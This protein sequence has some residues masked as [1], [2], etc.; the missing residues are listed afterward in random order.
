MT[1]LDLCSGNPRRRGYLMSAAIVL[2]CIGIYFHCLSYGITKSDD[3][4][5]ITN[6]LPFLQHLPNLSKVFTTDAFYQHKSIDLYRPLQ[7]ATFILDAQWGTDVVFTAHLTNLILHILTCLTV[8]SLLKA[9]DFRE[10]FAFLG[11]LIYS[12]H[13]LFM[14]AV[15]WLPARGDLLLALCSFLALLFFIRAMTM[16]GWNN[17]LLHAVCFVCAVFSKESAGVLPVVLA[18]YLWSYGQMKRARIPQL[19]FLFL[20]YLGVLAGYHFLKS[21]AVVLYDGDTGIAPLLKNFRTLPETMAKFFIPLNV[22]T[23]PAYTVEATTVGCLII[24]GMGTLLF[25]CRHKLDRRMLFCVGWIFLF[26]LPAML[27]YPVFYNFT[28]EHVDHRAYTSCFGSLLLSLSFAQ[29]FNLDRRRY[30]LPVATLLLVYLAV[31][32]LFFSRSYRSPSAFAY[33]AMETN[34]KSA[35]AYSIYGHELYLQ[36][37]DKGAIENLNKSLC[38]F[39][40]W[41]PALHTRALI[42]LRHGRDREAL[43]DLDAI[44]AFEPKYGADLYLLRARAKRNLHDLEGA[45]QDCRKALKLEPG[46]TEATAELSSLDPQRGKG[47][48]TANEGL[49]RRY[50]AEGIAAGESGDFKKAARLF[51]QA[52]QAAPELYDINVNLGRALY[53]S[54]KKE[55]ACTAWKVARQHGNEGV[56]GIMESYC[57][58]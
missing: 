37:D 8:F 27:Y 58:K 40:N 26:M 28:Y 24:A 14:T 21:G 48:G 17:Y 4:I 38:I 15:A 23:L 42:L 3:D 44:A 50:N 31:N 57:D 5:L 36:G 6:N 9:L 1:F 30:F 45:I 29:T 33:R 2:F 49:A 7:S 32:N 20:G 53:A 34:P 19:I 56:A 39:K 16:G 35:L 12:V 11:S 10:S 55:E 47:Q 51:S 25:V 18:L 41:T 52:L 54:G 13:Y 43:A 22:S 46:S